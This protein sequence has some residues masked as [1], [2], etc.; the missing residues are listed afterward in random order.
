MCNIQF[1]FR[2]KIISVVKMC[3]KVC[4]GQYLCSVFCIQNSLKQQDGLL[5]LPYIVTG[6]RWPKWIK[7]GTHQHWGCTVDIH[8]LNKSLISKQVDADVY[9]EHSTY[10]CFI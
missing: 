10:S 9:A 1:G 4:V 8:L 7:I 2:K 6:P 5:C 3:S